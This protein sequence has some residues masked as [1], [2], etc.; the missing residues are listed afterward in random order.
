MQKNRLP[1]GQ[2]INSGE[3]PVLDLGR[4][5]S[6]DI[7]TYRFE[8]TGLV[9]KPL[10][11][12]YQDLLALP[13]TNYSIDFHCVTHWSQFDLGWKGISWKVIAELAKPLPSA[14]FTMQ[15]GLDDYTVNNALAELQKPN[16]F[17]ALELNGKPL[18]PEHGAPLRLIIPHLYGWKGSKFL[19]EIKLTAEDTPGFWEDRGYHMHGDPWHEERF[20]FLD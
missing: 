1:P 11:L 18:T 13:Q 16:V 10:S 20:S 6:F 2:Y 4:R 19:H 3:M 5:P 14:K 17:L 12:S 15:Y 9:A 8:V 7:N